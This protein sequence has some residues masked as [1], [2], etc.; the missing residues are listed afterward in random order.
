[1]SLSAEYL[2]GPDN[3]IVDEKSR[4]TQSLEDW[5]EV[6][7]KIMMALRKLLAGPVSVLAQCSADAVCELEA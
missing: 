1:M 2:P 4:R 7:Q 3:D 5:K 6:I